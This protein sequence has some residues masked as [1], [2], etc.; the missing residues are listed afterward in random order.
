MRSQA[1][2][3]FWAARFNYA[4]LPF[5]YRNYTAARSRFE[6]L[7]AQTDASKQ[8]REVEL[9]QFK[10]FLTLLLEGKV[11]GARSFM[12]HLSFTGNDARAV[13][14]PGGVGVLRGQRGQ[15]AGRDR[16][17]PTRIFAAQVG[18][19]FQGVVLPHR[20]AQRSG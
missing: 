18:G 3:Q 2:P 14:L 15:G 4:E 8:P 10:I 12:G 9:T 17:R 5:N 1:D 7:S 11:D 19:Y 20:L 13:L 16:Q 6:E